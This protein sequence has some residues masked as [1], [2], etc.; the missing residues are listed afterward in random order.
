M[1]RERLVGA[2]KRYLG[3]DVEFYHK[4]DVLVKSRGRGSDAPL[5]ALACG[6]R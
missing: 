4:P 6:C 2:T 1:V 3:G 5:E